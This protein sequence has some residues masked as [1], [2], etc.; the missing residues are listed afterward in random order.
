MKDKLKNG[1]PAQH[2]KG[3]DNYLEKN[4]FMFVKETLIFKYQQFARSA[5][6]KQDFKEGKRK[7]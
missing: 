4:T 1:T 5:R 3:L 7:C 6:P 2:Q